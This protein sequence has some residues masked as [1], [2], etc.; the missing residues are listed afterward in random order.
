VSND[1]DLAALYSGTKAFVLAS[2]EEG[3]GLPVLEA[4]ACGAPV[5]AAKAG[6]LPEVAGEA[7]LMVD[8]LDVDELAE[9]ILRVVNN[10]QLRLELIRKGFQRAGDYPWE[11]TAGE[12]WSA[13]QDVWLS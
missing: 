2:L 10:E 6:A 12:I 5:I 7:G 3:F 9:A 8:P 13:F 1:T 4:M 11:R